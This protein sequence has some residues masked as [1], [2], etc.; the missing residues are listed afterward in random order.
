MHVEIIAEIGTNWDPNDRERTIT[1]AIRQAKEAGADLV[2]FQDWAPIEQMNRPQEWKDRCAPW[3]LTEDDRETINRASSQYEIP[4]F[5]SVFT[6]DASWWA[7]E[8]DYPYVK[9][10]SSE[11]ANDELLREIAGFDVVVSFG[12]VK[13]WNR[14]LLTLATINAHSQVIPMVCLA[15]YPVSEHTLEDYV[16]SVP[17]GSVHFKVPFVERLGPLGLRLGWSSHVPADRSSAVSASMVRYYGVTMVE[18]H[19]RFDFT[20]SN[21]PDNGNWSLYPDE[22]KALVQAV[23]EAEGE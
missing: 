23:R 5:C 4:W 15:E 20:A 8:Y 3:T 1:E 9:I 19:M 17:Y 2:K 22:F 18:A 16:R 12:E 21:A 11:A 13:D 14:V 6:K 7:Y 10:A